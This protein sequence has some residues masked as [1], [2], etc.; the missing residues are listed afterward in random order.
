MASQCRRNRTLPCADAEAVCRHYLSTADAGPHWLVG[1]VPTRRAAACRRLTDRTA[2]RAL[3][4]KWTDVATGEHGD[5][6]DLIARTS[7]LGA[8][9]DVLEE[10]RRSSACQPEPPPATPGD[11]RRH[12]WV[13]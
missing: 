12:Q 11:S 9:R 8:F 13:A 3:P 4:G 6:L 5:L 2:E 7:R 10:A 1:D